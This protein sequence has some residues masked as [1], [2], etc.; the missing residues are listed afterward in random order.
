[1]TKTWKWTGIVTKQE[2]KNTQK[3]KVE[4]KGKKATRVVAEEEVYVATIERETDGSRVTLRRREDPFD[5][6][7]GEAV[8]ITVTSSQMTLDDDVTKKP[9][10]KA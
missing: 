5:L 10:K 7:I 8:T 9:G 2:I 4:G 3:S 6:V 1:M